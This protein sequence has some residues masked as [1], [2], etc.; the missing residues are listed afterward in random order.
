MMQWEPRN[1][2]Q[3]RKELKGCLFTIGLGF[4]VVTF[5]VA[6]WALYFVFGFLGVLIPIIIGLVLLRVRQKRERL[7]K[8][9]P[10]YRGRHRQ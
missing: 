10:D 2:D 9:R 5:V 6:L 8:R 7:R 3:D 1:P 4:A